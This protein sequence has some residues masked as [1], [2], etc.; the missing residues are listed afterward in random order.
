MKIHYYPAQFEDLQDTVLTIGSFD[1]VHLGHAEILRKM[2]DTADKNQLQTCLITFQPHPREVLRDDHSIRLITSENEKINL[3][4]QAGLDHLV[5]VQFDEEFANQSAQDYVKKFLVQ[6]FHPKFIVIGYDHRFGKN[7]NGN[8]ALLKELGIQC[9][10]QIIETSAQ[11]M[12]DQI[13]SSTQIREALLAG[14]MEKANRMLGYTFPI[15]GMVI[16][17]QK[18]GRDLGFPTANLQLK[19][20]KKIIPKLG[21]YAVEVL[22]GQKLFQGMLYIGHRPSIAQGETL[23]IEVHIFEFSQNIYAQTITLLLKAYIRADQQFDHL[24][25]LQSQLQLDQIN[26]QKILSNQNSNSV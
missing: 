18:L 3:L 16:H 4:Q 5:F 6:F 8:V 21:I 2:R 1:G 23:S 22:V 24:A 19:D 20:S 10:F 7:Q 14:D 13:I 9:G 15:T 17:G 12:K 11:L 25:D 26:A